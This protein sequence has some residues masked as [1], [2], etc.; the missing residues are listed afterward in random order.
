MDSRK[1]ICS[2]GK[3]YWP[4]QAW[5]HEGCVTTSGPV[6]T[7]VA[8][9]A[10]KLA[11]VPLGMANESP[12]ADARPRAES[13]ANSAVSGDVASRTYLYRDVEARRA[14]QREYMRK[15]RAEK[16]C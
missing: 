8:N 3:A 14:Y 15:Y 1:K 2:C 11:N 4:N 10:D 12:K 5:S 6:V 7:D 13:R 9:D 16:N